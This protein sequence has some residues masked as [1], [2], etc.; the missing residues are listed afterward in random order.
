[1]E[2]RNRMKE[3]NENACLKTFMSQSGFKL[4]KNG[5]EGIKHWCLNMTNAYF[6]KVTYYD[7]SFFLPGAH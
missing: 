5:F 1:M 4:I 2:F 3:Q 6:P 7:S